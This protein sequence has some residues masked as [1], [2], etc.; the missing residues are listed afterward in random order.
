MVAERETEARNRCAFTLVEL[1]VVSA[2]K[3]TA[4]TLVELLVVIAIIGI[5]VALLL[6]AIQAAREASRRTQCI[7]QIRQLGVAV[8]NFESANKHFPPA[9]N[10][11]SFSYLAI[12]LPYYEGQ[13][14]YD[15]IDFARRPSDN[16]MPDDVPFKCPTQ[17]ATEPVIMFDGYGESAPPWPAELGRIAAIPH[18]ITLP[19]RHRL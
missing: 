18:E 1:P 5:L 8:L 3:R 14:A 19:A 16:T 17:D 9:V 11:G 15:S 6:P 4:F 10:D 2:R 7:S 12:T 13:A